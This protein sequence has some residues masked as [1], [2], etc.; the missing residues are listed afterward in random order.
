MASSERYGSGGAHTSSALPA[1]PPLCAPLAG[2]AAAT[3]MSAASSR[4]ATSGLSGR[5]GKAAAMRSRSDGGG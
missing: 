5:T 4:G 3:A 2:D 1:A